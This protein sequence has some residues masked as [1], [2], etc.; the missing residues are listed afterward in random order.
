M[1]S[2]MAQAE[3]LN[4]QVLEVGEATSQLV[5]ELQVA[6][7][8]QA[9]LQSELQNERVHTWKQS[10]DVVMAFARG[11]TPKGAMAAGGFDGSRAS[12]TVSP[13]GDATPSSPDWRPREP[14]EED[15]EELHRQL[16]SERSSWLRAR[17][18]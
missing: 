4:Q 7:E 14:M 5:E 11:G 18:A 8:S 17:V 12:G 1:T 9:R 3:E 2:V 16:R 15:H 10:T 6:T 13:G